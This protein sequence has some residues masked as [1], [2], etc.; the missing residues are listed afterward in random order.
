MQ[1]GGVAAAACIWERDAA[2]VLCVGGVFKDLSL[3]AS[4]C[5]KGQSVE[6]AIVLIDT[7]VG[8]S[9]KAKTCST[10]GPT[11]TQKRDHDPE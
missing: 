2:N 5:M 4:V 6:K 9:S 1:R 11:L 7:S 3:S 10:H 8:Q